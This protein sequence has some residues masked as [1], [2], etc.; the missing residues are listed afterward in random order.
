MKVSVVMTTYNGEKYLCQML[1]SL[2]KQERKID[3]VLFFDD[4]STDGTVSLI[5]NYIKKYEIKGW[6]V[7]VNTVNLGWEENFTKGLNAAS[8]DIIFP[9][10][11]DDIW[12]LDKVKKMTKAFEDN[13]E[14]LLLVSGY[15]AFSENG[16]KLVVQQKVKT[17]SNKK[18]SRVVFDRHYY[19]ILRPGCTMGFRREILPLFMNLWKSGTPH[20][21]LLWA[22]ASIQQRLYLYDEI[23]IE[24]R[25]H[26][27]NASKNISHGYKY[28]V[29]E[30][31][32]T[33]AVNQW[34]IN[35]FNLEDESLMIISNCNIW[36]EYR[37]KLLK[38]RKRYYWIKLLK[39]CDYYLTKKKYLGDLYYSFAK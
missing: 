1:D 5:E 13:S 7:K 14:I 21:A 36:C 12:H 32:R 2:R 33:L 11:Q 28:K 27:A 8:G 35:N 24:Y 6:K 16:G 19:Q 34:Y 15:H 38:E 3:E 29:N 10:D 37:M 18:I 26:D 4:K 20:D 23:F 17:E 25:R 39:Y 22:I 31:E 30:A 9:C